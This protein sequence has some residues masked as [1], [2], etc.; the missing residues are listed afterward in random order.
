MKSNAY[1]LTKR[2]KKLKKDQVV[3]KQ[4]DSDI[5]IQKISKIRFKEGPSEFSLSAQIKEN[6]KNLSLSPQSILKEKDQKGFVKTPIDNNNASN[7]IVNKTEEGRENMK[8]INNDN[9]GKKEESE[10][11]QKLLTEDKSNKG[12]FLK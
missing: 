2:Q 5:E 4:V 7:Y 3:I 12:H 1:F 9:K 8:N 10:T 6:K 11:L